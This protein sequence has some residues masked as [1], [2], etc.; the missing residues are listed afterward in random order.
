MKTE[1]N[2]AAI[3]TANSES[4]VLT[5]VTALRK[6]QIDNAINQFGEQFAF[7]DYGTGLEFRDKARLTEFF[8]KTRELYPHSLLLTDSIFVSGDH[9]ISEWTV[10]DMITERI[11]GEYSREVPICVHGV[12][13]VRIENGE[14]TEWSDYYD[15]LTSR[16]TALASYFTDWI[17]V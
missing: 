13:V 3:G 14:I 9:V 7:N 8:Q 17:D 12:S 5:V 6:G 11:F 1:K 10:R 16:R 4:L 15:R 2:G